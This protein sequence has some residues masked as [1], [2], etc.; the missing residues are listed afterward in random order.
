MS[1]LGIDLISLGRLFDNFAKIGLRWQ[2]EIGE[3]LFGG[4]ILEM[5]LTKWSA[6]S[7]LASYF[8]EE[9][10]L[11]IQIRA[12]QLQREAAVLDDQRAYIRMRLQ[13]RGFR[14]IGDSEQSLGS[15]LIQEKNDLN[16]QI[17]LS[18]ALLVTL[19]DNRD[20][21]IAEI[22][23]LEEAIR[24]EEQQQHATSKFELSELNSQILALQDNSSASPLMRRSGTAFI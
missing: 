22:R 3:Q 8:S 21:L 9:P 17:E 13:A 14:L 4:D 1:C 15:Q 16:T 10:D 24:A 2:T 6:F 23:S 18:S 5:D 20:E 12:F 7:R 19:T 11:S